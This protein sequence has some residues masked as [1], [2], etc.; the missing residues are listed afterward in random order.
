MTVI[1]ASPPLAPPP[2]TPAEIEALILALTAA[3]G[4]GKSICPSEVARALRP[5]WQTLLTAV[6]RAASRL[7]LAGQVEILRKGQPVDPN[8]VKGVIRL[9]QA[10]AAQSPAAPDAS[11]AYQPIVPADAA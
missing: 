11:P 9:R 10:P 3:R 4:P 6:R 2:A 7:A 8:G 1:A 5:D